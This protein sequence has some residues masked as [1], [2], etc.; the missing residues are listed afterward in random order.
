MET[1]TSSRNPRVLAWRSL[2]DK[3][4]RAD[5]DAFLVEGTK[6]V[7]EALSSGFD[8]LAVENIADPL[9]VERRG[10]GHGHK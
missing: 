7:R 6:M 10:V 1:I 8:V 2:R 9:A 4:G 5:Q 3:K